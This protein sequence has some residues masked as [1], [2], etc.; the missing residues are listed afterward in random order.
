MDRKEF[1]KNEINMINN[2]LTVANEL[3]KLI[4]PDKVDVRPLNKYVEIKNQVKESA[5]NA[6]I[7]KYSLP[8]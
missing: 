4:D 6:F 5:R 1:I 8:L 7:K 2:G 3:L